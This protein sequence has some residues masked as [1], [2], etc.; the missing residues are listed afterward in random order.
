M[1]ELRTLERIERWAWVAIY[2]GI[3]AI[4]LGVVTGGVH[5]VAG[6]SLGAIGAA[7]IATGVV[8]IVLRSRLGETPAPGA[9]SQSPGENP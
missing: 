8:L 3:F 1:A 5:L 9:Q 2:A 6:W 4:I 7:A